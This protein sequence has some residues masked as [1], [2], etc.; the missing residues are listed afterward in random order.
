MAREHQ[1]LPHVYYLTHTFSARLFDA[2]TSISTTNSSLL[3]IG[4][5]PAGRIECAISRST[6]TQQR[7]RKNR[8][9]RDR[10]PSFLLRQ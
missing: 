7:L 6:L 8:R 1:R 10:D 3:L 5:N 2:V 4:K 9:D